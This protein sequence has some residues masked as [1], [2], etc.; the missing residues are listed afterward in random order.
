MPHQD[1][2]TDKKTSNRSSEEIVI[3]PAGP[4]P[5]NRV[6]EVKPGETVRR[7]DDGTLEKIPRPD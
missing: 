2:E 3:T 1:S 4:V 5:K 6:P 7:K